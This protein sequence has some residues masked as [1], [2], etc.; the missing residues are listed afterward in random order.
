MKSYLKLMMAV[1]IMVMAAGFTSCGSS[2]SN[3]GNE[4]QD[5]SSESLAQYA[6][7]WELFQVGNGP[8]ESATFTLTIRSNGSASISHVAHVGYSD[9]WLESGDGHAQLNGDVLY[10]E[11]T[12]GKSAGATLNLIA[13]GGRIYTADGESFQ[14]Q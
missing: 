3:S 5:S 8:G 10:V 12:S 9:T 14:R 7:K 2:E 1:A 6:G 11:I 13:K 4:Y